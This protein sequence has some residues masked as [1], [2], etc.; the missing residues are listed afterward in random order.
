MNYN[1]QLDKSMLEKFVLYYKHFRDENNDNR[2]LYSFKSDDFI[3]IV[4][5][6]YKV[7]F[8]GKN[9]F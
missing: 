7:L 2:I 1:F 3:I 8:Q 6:S 9:G 5:N 4:Y